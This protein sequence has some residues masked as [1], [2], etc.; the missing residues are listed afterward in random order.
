MTVG[1][2]AGC[3]K[4]GDD[5]SLKPGQVPIRVAFWGAVEEKGIITDTVRNWE[6]THPNIKVILEHIPAMYRD[7]VT[8][9]IAG[10]NPPDLIFCEVNVFVAFFYK[11]TL[12]DMTPY[13]K[14]D[15]FKIK[16]FY[17]EVVTRFTRGGKVFCIP[18]DTA[19]FACIF[20]NKDLFN[21]MHVPVPKDSWN[22]AQFL[23]TATKMTLDESGKH[24]GEVGFNEKKIKQDG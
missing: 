3:G 10:G 7:K 14:R 5:Q 12:L 1:L 2:F 23:D 22:M 19:P 15:N 6:K 8:T 24:P 4:K 16:N 13:I 20:Y 11:N 9:E 18:R 21:K 17:P